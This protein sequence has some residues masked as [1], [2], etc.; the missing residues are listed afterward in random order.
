MLRENDRLSH[1]FQWASMPQCG[2]KL[3]NGARGPA[4]VLD[5]LAFLFMDDG[6]LKW[7]VIGQILGSK[8]EG[9]EQKNKKSKSFGYLILYSTLP[10]SSASSGKII[11]ING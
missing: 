1:K 6:Y 7:L 9:K 8:K 11:I 10:S 3:C 5:R 4:H 2:P